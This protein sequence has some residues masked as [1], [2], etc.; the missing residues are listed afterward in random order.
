MVVDLSRRSFLKAT[1]WVAGGLTALYFVRE[2]ATDVGPTLLLPDYSAGAAWL[3]VNPDGMTKMYC[4]RMEMGQNANT[5]LAQ[6]V[7]EE[8]NLDW[9]HIEIEYPNS[10]EVPPI[11]FT[12]GSLSTMLYAKPIALAAA[13]LRETLRLRAADLSK[14][15]VSEISDHLAGFSDPDGNF[16]SYTDLVSDQGMVLEPADF[17]DVSLYSFD[18]NRTRR[19]VG[20]PTAAYDLKEVVT[21]APLYA[22]DIRIDGQLYGRAIKPPVRTATIK[23][24][25]TSAAE[26]SPGFVRLVRDG[27]FV[28][29]VCKTP[30][31]LDKAIQQIKVEWHVPD[32]INQ[33]NVDDLIDVDRELT[34]GDLEHVL[35]DQA[36][37]PEVEWDVDL[38]FDVQIQTH[39]M[40]EP[41]A[42]VAN[43]ES[44]DGRDVLKIWTGTQDLWAIKRHAAMDLP[45]SED[46]VIVYP[47]RMGGGFGGR[48]HYDH[49]RDAARLAHAMQAPVKVQ[50]TREDEFMTSRSR[51]ASAHRVRLRSDDNGNLTD[52]WYAYITGHVFL[53]RDRLP[54]WLLPFKRLEGDLGV[55]RGAHPVYAPEHVRV[56][57]ADVDLPV[58]LGVWRSLNATP[59]IFALESAID[60]MARIVDQDPVE[61]RLQNIKAN[62]PRLAECLTSVRELAGDEPTD[63]AGNRGRG[64][65][66]GIYEH[67]S[68]VAV[69]ADVSVDSQTRSVTVTRLCCVQDVGMAVNPDQLKA[70]VESNLVWGIGMTLMERFELADGT[71]K[72]R[73]FHNYLIPR[74]KD[75]PDFRVQIIDRP[76]IAPAG[77]GEVALIAVPAAITNAIRDATGFRTQRLPV[78]FSDIQDNPGE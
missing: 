21:A 69:C 67:R 38:R 13:N 70:Q 60:E 19:H 35:I 8:L 7:C 18:S 27:D 39:A 76:E 31:T 5:G 63:P 20:N 40:S 28:G 30:G 49:E 77:A 78:T 2:R 66:C 1:G 43:I 14:A 46:D 55:V 73:N 6:I 61:Y 56:E 10:G 26:S 25:D 48:E 41:R 53:A 34:H 37:D 64:Y 71:I 44:V 54:G 52:L 24:I 68:Y 32:P 16:I 74:M 4:P 3:Q 17:Q 29:I 33:Q 9:E 23:S 50:W 22:A 36:H 15:P 45:F 51:P 12:A 47:M 72:S 65:A 75:V 57:C 42:A 59:A 11:L 62:E 58:D